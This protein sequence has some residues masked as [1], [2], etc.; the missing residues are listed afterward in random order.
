MSRWNLAEMSSKLQNHSELR[1]H[2]NKSFSIQFLNGEMVSNASRK[3]SGISARIFEAGA[4]GFSSHPQ[5]GRESVEKVL[6][7]AKA[8]AQFISSRSKNSS[9]LAQVK[10]AKA[11][12]D[13]S[14]K[15]QKFSSAD[16]I[17]LMKKYDLYLKTTFTDLKSRALTCM[18]Q[19]FI[20]EGMNS[21]GALT[22]SHYI[23]SFLSVNLGLDSSSGPVELRKVFGEPGEVEDTFPDFELFKSEV[24]KTYLHLKDKAVG[25]MPDG[26]VKQVILSSKLAGILAHEAVG[27]TTEADLVM[28][29][30]IAADNLEK[31]VAAPMVTMI[32]YAHTAFGKQA[33]MPVL[34]DDEGTEA[35][36]T[37]IIENGILKSFMN[38]RES[39]DHFSQK[40]NGHARAWA[41]NDEPLIRMRNTAILPGHSKLQEM[42][43]SV[44]DG[45]YL[46]D[47]SNGQADSTSE[48]MFGVTLGYEIK[49]GKLGRALRDTTISGVAF[50]ML[51][52]VDMLSDEMTWVSYGTCGK[53]Q[54]MTVGMGGPAVKCKI[55]VGGK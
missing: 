49:K 21:E 42:I 36:D 4:W 40:A 19:D 35:V 1:A 52:T 39:A 28:G 54:P 29:G 33:P 7:E 53:K 16:L 45:Y 55:H 27:H 44:D 3:D 12:I 34:F 48:F 17:E 31:S 23:R 20:K 30:S 14:T 22:Y 43:E 50:D 24:Q 25:I 32:D 26:G 6:K 15:K 47:H 5:I 51:K 10:M 2:E 11:Q 37:V 9:K 8:N 46:M 18:Q 38:S 13:L 41:F